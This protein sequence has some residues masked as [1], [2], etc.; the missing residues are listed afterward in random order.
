MLT[1]LS[2]TSLSYEITIT[3]LHEHY[4]SYIM[5]SESC[6]KLFRSLRSISSTFST[7]INFSMLGLLEHLGH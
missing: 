4:T 1:P 7:V 5:S 2:H 3:H 6:A